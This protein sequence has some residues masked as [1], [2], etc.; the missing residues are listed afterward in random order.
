MNHDEHQHH[1]MHAGHDMHE[2]HDM[3]AGHGDQDTAIDEL[4][5]VYELSNNRSE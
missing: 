3:H 5:R 1:D 2:G 4:L